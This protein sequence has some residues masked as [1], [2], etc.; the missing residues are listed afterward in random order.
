[1]YSLKTCKYLQV[2][3]VNLKTLNIQATIVF[4][5]LSPPPLPYIYQFRNNN[6]ISICLS[7]P[8]D[9][10]SGERRNINPSSTF[11]RGKEQPSL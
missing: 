5:H 7:K 1:M 8:A 9:L 10:N 2:D 4:F 11:S 3:T 6:I